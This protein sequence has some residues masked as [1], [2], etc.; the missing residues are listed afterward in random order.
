[1]LILHLTAIFSIY[2]VSAFV[3][4]PKE[5][6]WKVPAVQAIDHINVLQSYPCLPG[7]DCTEQVAV[8]WTSSESIYPSTNIFAQLDRALH[9]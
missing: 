5:I 3:L 2:F 1:M 9:R 8:L 6:V 4:P 7:L